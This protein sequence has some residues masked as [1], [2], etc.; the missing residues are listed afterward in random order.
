[1]DLAA[2]I[3]VARAEQRLSQRALARSAGVPQSTVGR[4]E[5]RVLRPRTDTV[6][7]L[8]DALDREVTLQ[9]RLGRGV[10]RSLIRSMLA[11]SPR[12]RLLYAVSAGKAIDRLRQAARPGV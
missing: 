3:R 11:K 12:E 6:E 1:M 5:T 2:W 7:R 10:D 8:L 4:I 9:R